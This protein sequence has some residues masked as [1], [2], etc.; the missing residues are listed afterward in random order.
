MTSP[1]DRRDADDA[2]ETPQR[3]HFERAQSAAALCCQR[4]GP[5]WPHR[6][7]CVHYVEPLEVSAARRRRGDAR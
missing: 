7:W 3:G 1:T 4:P 5:N 6:L 2:T